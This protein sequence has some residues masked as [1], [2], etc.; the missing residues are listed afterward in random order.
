MKFNIYVVLSLSFVGIVIIS[1]VIS[2]ALYHFKNKEV[3]LKKLNEWEN[4]IEDITGD[5]NDEE[6]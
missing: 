4:K 2:L 3:V 6:N 5:E 1:Y